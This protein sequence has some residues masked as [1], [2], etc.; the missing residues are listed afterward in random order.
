M[1]E[2][3]KAKQPCTLTSPFPIFSPRRCYVVT[4]GRRRKIANSEGVRLACIFSPSA[5]V[6]SF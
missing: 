5:G 4:A 3:G 1:E 6:A 2:D